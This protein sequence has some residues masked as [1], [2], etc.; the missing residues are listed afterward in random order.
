[1]GNDELNGGEGDDIL[2]GGEG[3][4]YLVDTEGDNEFWD[5]GR[6]GYNTFEG[7]S[8]ADKYFISPG[9]SYG[10]RVT[11]V[12][13]TGNDTIYFKSRFQCKNWTSLNA[14]D[15]I[16]PELAK[17]G[18]DLESGPWIVEIKKKGRKE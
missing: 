6:N 2:A 14:T 4:D 5:N 10:R 7:G 9:L 13:L 1:M 12:N 15:D 3:N 17:H 11:I 8:G 16:L 18:E